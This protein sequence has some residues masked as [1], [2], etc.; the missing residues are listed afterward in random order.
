[1]PASRKSPAD[2]RPGAEEQPEAGEQPAL[3]P[4]SRFPF[5]TLNWWKRFLIIGIP[6][7]VTVLLAIGVHVSRMNITGWVRVYG[8]SQLQ[9]GSRAAFR[10]LVRQ[11]KYSK[12]ASPVRIKAYF[13]TD[14]SERFIGE[15]FAG[16]GSQAVEVNTVLP[17]V[18]PGRYRIKMVVESPH[19]DETIAFSVELVDKPEK[20]AWVHEAPPGGDGGNYVGTQTSPL[21]P[22][23]D[24][25]I[26]SVNPIN[27]RGF[28]MPFRDVLFFRA[29]NVQ[30]EP[31]RARAQLK[32]LRGRIRLPR[33]ADCNPPFAKPELDPCMIEVPEGKSVPFDLETDI[34][35]LA[36][37]S[38]YVMTPG[39]SFHISYQVQDPAGTWGARREMDFDVGIVEDDV[40]LAY[41]PR[42][43][44]PGT[45]FLFPFRGLGKGPMYVDV[46][47]DNAW[48][49][50]AQIPL[51]DMFGQARVAIDEPQSLRKMQISL[52]YMPLANST[53]NSTFWVNAQT[54]NP[55]LLEQAVKM[56]QRN[57]NLDGHTLQYLSA[58]IDRGLIWQPGY[59]IDNNIHYFAGL[60]D[61]FHFA[62]QVLTDTK[63][64]KEAVL[65]RYKRG[66]QKTVLIVVSTAG[67]LLMF[68]VFVA[69]Y[70]ALRQRK[71]S[72][73]EMSEIQQDEDGNET[74][75]KNL[76]KTSDERSARFQAVVYGLIVALIL[77]FIFV[78]FMWVFF[79]IKWEM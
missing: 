14:D 32:L 4:I 9:P 48:V 62:P 28:K 17:R 5:S 55:R 49:Y 45:S 20:L 74:F 26:V 23:A 42:I 36:S 44:P 30:G 8:L 72:V 59:S 21:K 70:L 34:L 13:L 40:F 67:L 1:M 10:V 54:N 19:A 24:G 43:L 7:L 15:G 77:G 12:P 33:H 38:L 68:V 47:S 50:A 79:N 52:F 22:D 69:V 75:W 61:T 2:S 57:E 78:A 66:S 27:G 73:A 71:R 37:M 65:S 64:H 16:P 39:V 31:V 56:A 25:V 35:G 53:V 58:L 46:Y 60:L 11:G 29:H 18:A 6:I 3:E 63:Q 51:T 76:H 41:F